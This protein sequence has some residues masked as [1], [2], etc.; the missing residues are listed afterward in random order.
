MK[1]WKLN[2]ALLTHKYCRAHAKR[3]EVTYEPE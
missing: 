1:K 3:D 2:V